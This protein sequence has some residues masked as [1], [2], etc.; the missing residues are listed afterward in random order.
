MTFH[1]YHWKLLTIFVFVATMIEQHAETMHLKE[2]LI[3]F[4]YIEAFRRRSRLLGC[5]TQTLRQAERAYGGHP[6]PKPKKVGSNN[7]FKFIFLR[8]P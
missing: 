3:S 7:L 2:W 4:R 8:L 1:E 5:T 6:T